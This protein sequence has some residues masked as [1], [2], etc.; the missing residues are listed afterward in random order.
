MIGVWDS[1]T[2]CRTTFESWRMLPGQ[3]AV[4]SSSR[5]TVLPYDAG[6]ET[7]AAYPQA[8][9]RRIARNVQHLMKMESA[10]DEVA[11][12]AAGSYYIE[13]LTR[14]L[15]ERAWEEFQG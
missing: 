13:T 15:A 14:Q 2:F 9:S 4:A 7:Q 8:F 5:L 11:D 1:A 3:S 12:P 6:R 10:L